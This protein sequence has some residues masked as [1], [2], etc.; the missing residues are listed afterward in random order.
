MPGSELGNSGVELAM[1]G[2]SHRTV[3]G[4][5]WQASSLSSL[6][7]VPFVGNMILGLSDETIQ[8]LAI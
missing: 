1:R 8:G 2:G 4:V 6:D 7:G 5:K 3:I